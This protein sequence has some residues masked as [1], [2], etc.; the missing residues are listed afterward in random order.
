MTAI[1]A[2]WNFAFS[3]TKAGAFAER[4]SDRL[5]RTGAFGENSVMTK[6][7]LDWSLV[8]EGREFLYKEKASIYKDQKELGLHKNP[9]AFSKNGGD[10]KIYDASFTPIELVKAGLDI[11]RQYVGGFYMEIFPDKQGKEM[12]FVLYNDVNLKS[13]VLHYLQINE[14]TGKEVFPEAYPR[15]NGQ[16][17]PLGETKQILKWRENINVKRFEKYLK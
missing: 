16:I 14:L 17:T 3:T 4:M 13:L 5:R 1:F 7:V 8:E 6:G 9:L 15:I 12:E 11:V 2:K 10:D